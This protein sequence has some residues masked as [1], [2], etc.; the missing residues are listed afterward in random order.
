ML[1]KASPLLILIALLVPAGAAAYKTQGRGSDA[2]RE[3]TYYNAV[4]AHDWAVERAVQAWNESG[5][6]IE[7]VPAS[8]G[9]AELVI[10]GGEPGFDGRTA[11]TFHGGGPRPGD[12]KV[13]IPSPAVARGRDARFKVALI[14]A[15]ELGHALRLDHEDAGCALMN[16]TIVDDAPAR[17]SQPPPGKWR[18]GLVER[19]DIRGAVSLYGGEP[20]PPR[21]RFCPR[22]PPKR[23]PAPRTPARAPDSLS[24]PEGVEVFASPVRRGRVVVRWLNGEGERVRSAVVARAAGRCPGAPSDG[25]SKRVPAE[26]GSSG[27]A[28]F[29]LERERSCYA[30]W[31]RDAGGKLSRRPATAWLEAPRA[32]DPPADFVAQPTLS[33]ALGNTGVSLEWRNADS[34]TLAEVVIARGPGRC[35]AT[36]PRRS[37][38]W[39]APPASPGAFQEHSD[40]TFYPA[41][42]VERFCYAAW[43]R[44]RFGRLSAPV[45]AWPQPKAEE[46]GAIVLAG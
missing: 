11:T 2:G 24:T 45:T 40:L 29:S 21:R 13:S 32:P 36:P 9:E 25:E 20:I 27:E 34:G 1:H 44:D 30:V 7:F 4:R 35:P 5:A 19:D 17:C 37:R 46:D 10:T 33:H 28:T 26:P 42:R 39:N 43:S 18:C 41:G 14:T 31:S 38:P 3:I 6:N 23:K 16:S 8:R 15:H 12:I 22:V